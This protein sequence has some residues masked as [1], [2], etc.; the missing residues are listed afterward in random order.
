L[1]RRKEAK[2]LVLAPGEIQIKEIFERLEQYINKSVILKQMVV[3]PKGS[4]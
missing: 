1:L 2:I 3:R 4:D